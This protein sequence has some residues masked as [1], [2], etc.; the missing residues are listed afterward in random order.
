MEEQKKERKES[1]L[2]SLYAQRNKL[3][4][5]ITQVQKEEKRITKE[6]QTLHERL[7]GIE[8][9]IQHLETREILITTHC[10]ERFRERIGPPD[11]E[12]STVRAVLLTPQVRE[13]IRVLGS[14]TYPVYGTIQAVVEDN[15]VITVIDTKKS[16]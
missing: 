8:K 11:A 12:E 13:M 3:L 6:L 1:K 14:G 9:G 5:K 15:K 2:S 10:I 4:E 7:I 16:K